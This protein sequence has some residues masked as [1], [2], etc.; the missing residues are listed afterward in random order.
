MPDP[1]PADRFEPFPTTH[2]S[3]VNRAGGVNPERR[4]AL[5][6]LGRLYWKPI[7][8]YVRLRWGQAPEVAADLTQEFFI[9]MLEGNVLEVASP[10]RGSF[11]RFLKICL[12]NFVKNEIR[13]D[14]AAMRGGGMKKLSLDFGDDPE[15]FLARQPQDSPEEIFDRHWRKA[16][17]DAALESLAEQYRK[18]GRVVYYDVFRRYDL[19]PTDGSRPTYEDLARELGVAPTEIEYYLR[20]ARKRIFAVVQDLIRASVGNAADFEEEQRHFFAAKPW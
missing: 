18:E 4:E 19:A 8:A 10:D 12:D 9:H 13:R 16:I 20:H 15:A 7:Y 6:N 17:V 11:R 5:E 14:R 2:W 1:S 3:V